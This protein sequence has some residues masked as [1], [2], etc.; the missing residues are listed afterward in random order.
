MKIT[1]NILLILFF[2]II[3]ANFSFAESSENIKPLQTKWY[4]V[5][6]N[7]EIGFVGVLY[8]KIKFAEDDTYFD[9]KKDGGQ[10]TLYP[11]TRFSIEAKFNNKHNVIFLYQPLEFNTTVRFKKNTTIGSRTFQADETVNAIYS[12]PFY[13]LSYLN[14]LVNNPLH[15]LSIGFGLQIRNATITFESQN[16]STTLVRNSNVGPVPLLK[17]RAKYGLTNGLWF[18]LEIDGMYAP[19]SYLNGSKRDVTGAIIDASVRAGLRLPYNL[20]PYVNIRHIGGGAT[21]EDPEYYT[22]NWIHLINVSLG[23]NVNL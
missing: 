13:R 22:K 11:I 8:H 4:T 21:N 6:T 18:G 9:Y 1:T 16:G 12:F 2:S 19:I 5:T 20:E 15:E 7:A 23:V 3:T 14:N 10:D 17:A